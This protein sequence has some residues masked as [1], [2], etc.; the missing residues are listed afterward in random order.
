MSSLGLFLNP[1]SIAV[2]GASQNLDSINGM[3]IKY[4]L[5]HGYRGKIFPVNPKYEEIAGLK[6]YPGLLQIEEEIDLV[7]IAIAS[8]KV[9]SAL[10]ECAQKGV[11]AVM[12]YSSG[13][14][15]TGE[16]GKAIQEKI[17]KLS[18]EHG[19][20][21]CGPNCLGAANLHDNVVVAFSP[22]LENNL[23]QGPISFIS[24][25]GAFG[26][27]TFHQAQVEEGVGFR[28]LITTGNE[29]DVSTADFIEHAAGDKET[30]AIL[31]YMEGIKDGETL[32]RAARKALQADI[33]LTVFKVG[34]SDVGQKA[35]TSHTAALAGSDQIVDAFFRQ[36]A[37]VRAEHS[38]DLIDMAKIFSNRRRPGGIR[39]GVLTTSGGAGIMSADTLIGLGM[40]IPALDEETRKIIEEAIPPFGSSMNPVDVTAQIFNSP[41]YLTKCLRAVVEDNN[42]DFLL[43]SMSTVDGEV[44][45]EIA[46]GIVEVYGQAEKPIAVSWGTSPGRAEKAFQI[47]KQAGVPLYRQPVR[48]AKALAK[49]ALYVQA[50]REIM[51]QAEM[52]AGGYAGAGQTSAGN[53]E[54]AF[55]AFTKLAEKTGGPVFNEYLSKELLSASGIPITRE[56][57]ALNPAE[58]LQAAARIGYPLALKVMSGK[59]VH[60]TEAGVVAI[61]IENEAD[62]RLKFDLL[63]QNALKRVEPSDIE[64]YLVQEM[65]KPGLEAIIGMKNDPQF[66]PTIMFGLGGIFV[67]LLEDVVF[68][69]APLSEKDALDM[70]EEIKGAK[71]LDG[72][73]G[74]PG[75]NRQ[76]LVQ[77]LINFS[78][79]ASVL[80]DEVEEIDLNP[81]IL[82]PDGLVVVDALIIRRIAKRAITHQVS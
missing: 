77:L 9:V 14:A 56:E 48:C 55:K 58:A 54:C 64:G 1:R 22:V 28:Y 25:S 68:R 63:R 24:Q 33:P 76:K 46:K 18:R 2:I 15:E 39:A 79:L 16:S 34:K 37:V 8:N 67:E 36:N 57:L 6:C 61:N 43:I 42:I 69:V 60:K 65:A 41:H 12:V 72:F 27:V 78:R 52:Q 10:E 49:L 21:V 20:A 38:D 11:R 70:L 32:K 73:R 13:F 50:R 81:V 66:G 47:L 3:L 31:C 40:Q 53:T 5:K 23:I 30:A 4:L 26:F 80:G 51:G 7:L 29:A 44:G 17:I 59:L 19:I 62:L 35:I 74:M 45:A 82:Y 75:A 71:A